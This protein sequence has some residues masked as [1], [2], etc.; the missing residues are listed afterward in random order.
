VLTPVLFQHQVVK[1]R[2]SGP[3]GIGCAVGEV[4]DIVVRN[5]R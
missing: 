1:L 2:L 4:P 3:V 5:G